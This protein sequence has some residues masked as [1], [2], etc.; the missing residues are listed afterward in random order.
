MNYTQAM[1][2]LRSCG[3]E[4]VLAGWSRLGAGARR[5]LLAQVAQI[6]PASVRRCQA[7]L[8]A[9]GAVADSSKG[10]APKVAVLSGAARRRAVE[11]GERSFGIIW[12][13][14]GRREE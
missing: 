7:A 1:A 13:E 6:D 4:H 8:K 14:G 9:G 12:L 2:M 3:Q 5:G 10:V 11:A